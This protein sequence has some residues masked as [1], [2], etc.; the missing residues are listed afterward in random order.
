MF[1]WNGPKMP[2]WPCLSRPSTSLPRCKTW[3]R[4]TSPRMT[5]DSLRPEPALARSFRTEDVISVKR[6]P[7]ASRAHPPA[8]TR[9]RRDNPFTSSNLLET[10]SHVN[11]QLR[12]ERFTLQQAVGQEALGGSAE[13]N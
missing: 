2:S 12:S 5:C 13:G 8:P 10:S 11:D 9:L 6:Q 3:M 7:A 1:R 4:G